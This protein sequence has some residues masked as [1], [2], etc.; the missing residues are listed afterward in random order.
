M[1]YPTLNSI[2]V[3]KQQ[4]EIFK[5]YNH[6]YKITDGE[7]YDTKNITSDYY[8]VLATRKKRGIVRT[9]NE[10]AG[11]TGREELAYVDGANLFYGDN[12]IELGLSISEEP[13]QLVNMGAYLIVFP[14]KKY[15]NTQNLSDYG[16]LENTVETTD[17]VEFTPSKA[18]GSQF[19]YI[20]SDTQPQSPTDGMYWFDSVNNILKQYSDTSSMWTQV[21][22]TYVRLTSPGIGKGFNKYDG[23][24][25]SGCD[26]ED[27]NG[28]FVIN[29]CGEDYIVIIG[30][31]GNAQNQTSIVSVKR[32]VPD[33]DYVIES[34][35][36]L[37][38]CYYGYKNNEHI[39]EIYACKLGDPF[40]WN[41]FAG[42]STDSYAVSLGTDGNFTGAV[43]YMGYPYFFKEKCIHKIYGT[44]PSNY[45]VNTN[46]CR[47]VQRGSHRSLEI[48][49]E[50][51]FYKST[52]CICAYSGSQPVSVSSALGDVKYDNAV[53]GCYRDK[54]Y[55]SMR[56][57]SNN[58]YHLFAYDTSKGLWIREDNTNVMAFAR[59]DNDLYYIDNKSNTIMNIGGMNAELEDDVEWYAESGNIGYSDANRKYISRFNIRMLLEEGAYVDVFLQYNSSGVWEHQGKVDR[60]GTDCFTLPIRP[61]RCDHLK[62][63]LQGRGSCKVFLLAKLYEQGGDY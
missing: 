63:K 26:N 55:I 52:D 27:F 10:P 48:V 13:K 44:M 5:G 19:D 54:Y 4:T 34:N 39:N 37:W 11:I 1:Y 3:T 51:L 2:K 30:I 45:Q 42:I 17:I 58:E 20:V 8:P 47:G 35:N 62:I 61:K 53:A 60:K 59:Y 40:N 33:M 49:N 7:F 29:D 41:C 46:N 50:V 6:N 24:N 12:V 23:V 16:S 56:D 31:I 36:R 22:T 25:I 38:G 28:N 21:A 32:Q 9:L 15:I 43:A 57:I 18:D 14:D